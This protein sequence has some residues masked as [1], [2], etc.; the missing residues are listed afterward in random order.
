[1]TRAELR[2]FGFADAVAAQRVEFGLGR[3]LAGG[4]GFFGAMEI[5]TAHVAHVGDQQHVVVDVERGLLRIGL[6]LHQRREHLVGD[7]ERRV[8]PVLAQQRLADVDDDQARAADLA[9]DVDRQVVDDAAVDHETAAIA[10]RCERAGYRHRRADRHREIAV[11]ED[12]LLAV[13]DVGG[14]RAERNRQ[15]VEV[16]ELRRRQ[17]QP[18]QQ[19]LQLLALHEPARQRD[20][21]VLESQFD[22][23]EKAQLVFLAPHRQFFARGIV[24]E[25]VLPVDALE[26][27]VDRVGVVARGIQAA[28]DRAHRRAGDAV[29]RNAFAFEH[30]EHADMRR[31]ARAAAAEHEAG[32]G[33][34]DRRQCC[35]Q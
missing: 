25:H 5:G 29:D 35:Q 17:Q 33:L 30:L 32:P 6:A 11:G 9:R 34:G 20:A 22:A 24:A 15:L 1:M 10:D 31:A 8:E 21:A 27:G 7:A 14:D 16:G 28:G 18:A 2:V 4:D 3:A 26:H 19:K 12:D 13:A 23:A